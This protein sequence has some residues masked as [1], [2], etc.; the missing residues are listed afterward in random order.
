[1]STWGAFALYLL[2]FYWL[3][4]SWK[5]AKP[6]HAAALVA[7]WIPLTIVWAFTIILILPIE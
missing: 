5:G 7:I 1:M 6:K 4:R 2:L 3:L